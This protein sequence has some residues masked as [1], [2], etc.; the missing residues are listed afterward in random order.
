MT[1]FKGQAKSI[2]RHFDNAKDV[3]LVDQMSAASKPPVD[4]ETRAQLEQIEREGFVVLRGLLTPEEVAEVKRDTTR[5][6]ND[7]E[8]KQGRNRFEGRATRRPYGLLGKSRVYDKILIHPRVVRLLDQLL[9]P[10]YLVTATQAIEI[11]PGDV[12]LSCFVLV[13]LLTRRV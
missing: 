7:E 5:I 10:N 3:V 13:L 8:G 11:L 4:A 9:L 6:M 1:D 12:F 2:H